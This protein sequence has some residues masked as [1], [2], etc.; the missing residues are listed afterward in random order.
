MR[1]RNG[2]RNQTLFKNAIYELGYLKFEIAPKSKKFGGRCTAE[3]ALNGRFRF[4]HAAGFGVRHFPNERL[5][6]F[7]DAAQHL[8]RR[9]HLDLG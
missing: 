4:D 1:G 6:L 9:R 7:R 8:A 5:A 3:A 2:D